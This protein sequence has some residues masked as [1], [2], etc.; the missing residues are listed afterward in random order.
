MIH[1][2]EEPLSGNSD[3]GF[4][5]LIHGLVQ[6]TAGMVTSTEALVINEEGELSVRPLNTIKTDFRYDRKK[7]WFTANLTDND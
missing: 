6:S 4:E 7:G 2:F 3:D 1:W 5:I